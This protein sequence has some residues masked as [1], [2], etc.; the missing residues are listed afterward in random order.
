M[1]NTVI[2][3]GV[4]YTFDIENNSIVVEKG[5]KRWEQKKACTG[6][7]ILDKEGNEVFFRF[8]DAAEVKKELYS[9]GISYGL[10]C[11]F[12]GFEIDGKIEDFAY[13]TL[14]WVHRTSGRVYFELIPISEPCNIASVRWPAPFEFV[15]K[16]KNSYTVF[17][18]SQGMLIPSNWEWNIKQTGHKNF[19]EAGTT[20]PWYAQVDEGDGYLAIVETRWDCN[21]SVDHFGKSDIP[22]SISLIWMPSL[23]KIA[24]NRVVRFEFFEDTNYV[25]LAKEYRKYV[26][27]NGDLVTLEQKALDNPRIRDLA[28]SPIIHSYIYYYVKPEAVIYS[29]ENPEKNYRF[30]T[31]AKRAEQIKALAS[32]GLKKAYF[33]LD[34]WGVDGYDQQH[35]DIIPPCEKAGGVEELKKLH[36]TCKEND[37]IFALHDQYRDYYTDATYYDEK[38]SIKNVAG[39]VPHECTW[40]GGDQ[41]YLCQKLAGY[42]IDRNYDMLEDMGFKPDAVYL[43]V[44]AATHLDECSDPMHRM[45]K[46]DSMEL[47]RKCMS[48]LGSRGIIISSE[49]GVDAYIP[50]M[51]LCHHAY[52]RGPYAKDERFVEEYGVAIPLINLVYHDCFMIPWTMKSWDESRKEVMEFRFLDAL[53]NGGAGY[54]DIDAD[55][56][57][58]DKIS[59]LSSVHEKV[60]FAEMTNHE[61][62]SDDETVQ[63]T[64]FSNGV[65][66]TV[67]YAD[68]TFTVEE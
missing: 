1:E 14:I 56:A 52:Y 44:F 32:K 8:E 23:G 63:R 48:L 38:S 53:L 19:T 33:H 10:K 61:F 47:R 21:H 54:L 46:K 4:K 16:D 13:T 15:R 18:T 43:D 30:E 5:K 39:E 27:Q 20:M 51:V 26:K 59:I 3:R 58:L 60:A 12:R 49:S 6:L 36:E 35:P 62:L 50:N 17:P 9:D 40:N 31:F 7:N 55:Q 57:E 28:G 29:K 42:Y 66:I 34:G 45:T 64:T 41:S 22:T 11:D 67:N 25:K 37:V 68:N 65:K 2:I 24:Y